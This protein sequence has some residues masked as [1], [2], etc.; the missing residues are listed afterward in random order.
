MKG[1]KYQAIFLTIVMLL[2]GCLSSEPEADIEKDIEKTEELSV[3]F[4]LDDYPLNAEVGEFVLI[5]G[6]ILISTSETD[7]SILYD[8]VSPTGI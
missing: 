6:N 1:Q 5:S 3:N 8:I 2:S 7:Y 4:T